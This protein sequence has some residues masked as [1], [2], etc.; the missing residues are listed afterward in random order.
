MRLLDGVALTKELILGLDVGTSSVKALFIDVNGE[1]P[2]TFE[3]YSE[4]IIP[5][6][7]F[8]NLFA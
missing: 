2:I 5:D 6:N 8:F 1:I 4:N 3:H 7:T